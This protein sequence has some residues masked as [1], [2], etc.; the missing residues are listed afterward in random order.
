MG[1][2][3]RLGG[4][5]VG[6]AS[7]TSPRCSGIVRSSPAPPAGDD[8]IGEHTSELRSHSDLVC[9]L[10]LE[11]KKRSTA[12]TVTAPVSWL[13]SVTTRASCV[14]AGGAST[15]PPPRPAG[16]HDGEEPSASENAYRFPERSPRK[17]SPS[18]MVTALK[19]TFFSGFF[20]SGSLPT[21]S[22]ALSLHDAL[23]I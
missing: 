3:P 18:L 11:K 5:V 17:T 20:H 8:Q 19:Q 7:P 10:L 1:A 23:P 22:Y 14:A 6:R 12:A 4:S 16:D 2:R 9:R 13:R 21:R 15:E